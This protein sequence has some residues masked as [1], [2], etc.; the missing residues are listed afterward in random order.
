M[1]PRREDEPARTRGSR[2]GHA[3]AAAQLRRRPGRRSGGDPDQGRL[4][5]LL[6]PGDLRQRLAVPRLL[7]Q[8]P[9]PPR[10]RA[11]RSP[12]HLGSE[13]PRREPRHDHR[14]A[15]PRR[16]AL[17]SWSTPSGPPGSAITAGARLAA[18]QAPPRHRRA[19]HRPGVHLG[20]RERLAPA[21]PRPARPR[22]GPGR[23]R[24]RRAARA[25]STRVSPPAAA[26]TAC[27][28]PTSC[29][30]SGSTPT[31][32]QPPPVSTSPKAATGHRPRK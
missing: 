4:R 31:S 10:R 27:A 11:T 22:P 8:D 12:H 32:P 29:T 16:P 5:L 7:R 6:R 17:A 14:P 13:R 30:P 15:R 25:T 23:R 20:R 26:T 21:L 9:P 28:S 3:R 19:H 18:A 2:P 24:H 1:A